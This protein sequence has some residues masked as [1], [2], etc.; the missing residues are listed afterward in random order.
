MVYDG[1]CVRLRPEHP[2]HVWSYDFVMDRTHDGRSMHMLILID[3][4]TRE[5][6]AIDVARKI[7]ATD[8]VERLANL[9]VFH[10][11]LE[12]IRSDNGPEFVSKKIRCWL[13]ASGVQALYI[14]PR[15]PWEN[16]YIESFKGKLWDELLNCEIFE[17][18]FEAKVLVER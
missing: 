1:S 6:L 12:Y 13:K 5:C 8:V 10:G 18:L 4:Y 2:N 3:E 17:T 16:G 9:F 14:E 15:S 7:N 11:T